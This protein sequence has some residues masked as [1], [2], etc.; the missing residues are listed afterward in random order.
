MHNTC[1]PTALLVFLSGCLAQQVTVKTGTLQGIKLNLSDGSVA[2]VFLNIPY[3]KP[4]VG[5]LRFESPDGRRYPVLFHIHSSAY[6]GTGAVVYGYQGLAENF[7]PQDIIVVTIQHRVGPLG[8]LSTGDKNLPGNLGLFDQAAALKWTHENIAAFGGDNSRITVWGLSAGAASGGHFGLSPYTQNF[9]AQSI[10]MSGSYYSTWT[11][12]DILNVTCSIAEALGCS[13]E[14]AELKACLKKKTVQ[15]FYDAVNATGNSRRSQFFLKFHPRLDGDFFPANF[16][17]LLDRAP[18]KPTI[19]GFTQNESLFFTT[20]NVF[21]TLGGVHVDPSKFDSYS[22]KDLEADIKDIVVPKCLFGAKSK[23]MAERLL[24]T[25]LMWRI[26]VVLEVREKRK[27][28]WQTYL[29]ENEHFNPTWFNAATP[30][31]GPIHTIETQALFGMSFLS[32]NGFTVEDE[33]DRVQ[34][35]LLVSAFA[36]FV[37]NGKPSVENA[38][39]P[40]SSNANPLAYLRLKPNPKAESTL[41]PQLLAFWDKFFADFGRDIVLGKWRHL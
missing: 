30:L 13:D 1:V 10:Q 12:G 27:H 21:P 34:H 15:E 28:N 20:L 9:F 26:P 11:T 24:M 40:Q 2:D 36:S 18:P 41:D 39:W 35:K 5:D 22:A 37:K 4:P 17:T 31:T 6:A 19:L 8:F 32:P 16:S 38:S 33:Q 14:P 25:D 29:Y 7:V 23:S 3:A